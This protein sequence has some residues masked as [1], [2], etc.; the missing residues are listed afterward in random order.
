MRQGVASGNKVLFGL[1]GIFFVLDL[2]DTGLQLGYVGHMVRRDSVLTRRPG[3]DHRVHRRAVVDL[4]VRQA[5]V[6]LD[7]GR[8]SSGG[9]G[10]AHASGR[11]R[12]ACHGGKGCPAELHGQLTVR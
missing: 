2:Q 3:Y 5:K 12:A 4:L 11:R 6:E 9:R 8:G 10:I 7:R 1:A